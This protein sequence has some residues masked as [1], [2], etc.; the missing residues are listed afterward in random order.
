M[1]THEEA[2]PLA[3]R[4]LEEEALPPPRG[5]RWVLP[6]G[7]RVK[8]GWYFNFTYEKIGPPKPSDGFGGAPGFLVGDDGVV[9]VVGWGK[10][11]EMN[12]EETTPESGT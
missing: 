7:R 12:S 9:S 1:L 2:L 6:K 10:Y 4:Y 8:D 11:R 3:R 5:Y